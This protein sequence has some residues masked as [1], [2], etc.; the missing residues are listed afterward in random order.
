MKELFLR[1]AVF[2]PMGE[3]RGYPFSIPALKNVDK[4]I[5]SAP[6]TFLA[7]ENGAGKSTLLEALAVALGLN[8]EGGSQ[9]FLFSTRDTHS[10]LGESIRL[11]RGARRPRDGFFLRAES[12]YNTATKL[13]EYDDGMGDLLARYGG[14]PHE[15][16]HGEAFL[17]LVQRRFRD[18]I[19][20]MDEPEA[21]LSPSRQLSLLCELDRLA[22]GGSQMVVATHSPILMALPGAKIL[23]LDEMGIAPRR[24]EE[25]VHYQVTRR[26][27]CRP[28]QMLRKLGFPAGMEKGEKLW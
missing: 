10:A 1:E 20:L 24:W 18:G 3:R 21:A 19:Y 25:T 13:E 11:V 16:S 9:N 23:W 7:G 6:V 28:E 15:R 22:R 2:P 27:L 17:G 12:F 8:P 26:F 4:I 14:S 5:F